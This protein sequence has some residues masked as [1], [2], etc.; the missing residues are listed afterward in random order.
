VTRALKTFGFKAQ[1]GLEEGLQKTIAW[2]EAN[3]D[4]IPERQFATSNA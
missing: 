1:T 2:F 4:A 3:I